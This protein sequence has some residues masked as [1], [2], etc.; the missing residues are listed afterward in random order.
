MSATSM[1]TEQIWAAVDAERA[2]LAEMLAALPESDWDRPS[3][4][5]DWRVRDVVAHLV[6]SSRPTIGWLLFNVARARGNL[7]RA[8]RDTAI[9]RA[10]T[11]TSAQLLAELRD[12]VGAR[13]TPAGTTPDDR[14][15]D[16][17]VHGQDI[18]V[19]LGL[20]RTVPVAAA[21][22]ALDRLWHTRA[23]SHARKRFDGYRLAATDTEWMAGDGPVIEGS[24]AAL[25]MVSTGRDVA[26]DQ[27]TGAGSARWR[28]SGSASA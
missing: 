7:D 24:V 5:D 17:L 16:V 27:L 11:R 22:C 10:G 20:V 9:R 4:C 1:T 19:P 21:R 23:P 14:L 6:L 12:T 8:I 3:L 13:A 18:A 26:I 28:T 15:M 25:L 2:S